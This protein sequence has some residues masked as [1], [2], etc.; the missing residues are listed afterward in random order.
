MNNH[1]KG[2]KLRQW[3]TVTGACINFM[4][5]D[6]NLTTPSQTQS[7]N[8]CLTTNGARADNSQTEAM[9]EDGRIKIVKKIKR[10]YFALTPVPVVKERNI[11][12][13]NLAQFNEIFKAL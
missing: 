12:D 11:L 13:S 1:K 7:S 6:T 4:D 5:K 10:K 2:Y 9:G 3:G 8:R